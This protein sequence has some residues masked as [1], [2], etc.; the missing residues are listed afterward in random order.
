[1]S[2]IVSKNDNYCRKVFKSKTLT[3]IQIYELKLHDFNICF[4]DETEMDADLKELEL[5]QQKQL[6]E[7][8]EIYMSVCDKFISS[9]S[10]N[11]INV[12]D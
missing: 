1:M 2:N 5:N 11:M 3:N 12:M 10:P 7:I 6:L 9:R 4:K 8:L